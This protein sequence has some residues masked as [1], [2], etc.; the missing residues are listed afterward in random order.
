MHRHHIAH[1]D[2]SLRNVLTDGQGHYAFIDY[3]MSRR[4][5]GST[6]NPRI[7]GH[8]ATEI[9]PESERGEA[10]NPYKVDVWAIAVLILRGCQ[11]CYLKWINL[12]L[13]YN[14]IQMSGFHVPE[15]LQLIEPMLQDNPLNRPPANVVQTAF[16]SMV[17]NI[18]ETRLRGMYGT[19]SINYRLCSI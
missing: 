1:L 2:I 13:M 16:D 11:V 19:L 3:E 6:S 17:L 5:D 14:T 4:F 8:R 18:D 12:C 7:H 10:A 9:P 15:L